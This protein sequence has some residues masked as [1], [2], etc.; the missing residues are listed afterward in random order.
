M[1]RAN[2]KLIGAFVVGAVA[3]VVIGVA[4]GRG[5]VSDQKRTFVAYFEG[6]VKGLNVGARSSSRGCAWAR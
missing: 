2:P 4:A 1:N 3:L 6:S 5:Q